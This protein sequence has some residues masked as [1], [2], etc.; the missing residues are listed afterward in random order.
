MINQMARMD[1]IILD[2]WGLSVFN[3][4][5]R[6]DILEILDDRHN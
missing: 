3:D 2:D 1:L 6:R 4:Q 5:E